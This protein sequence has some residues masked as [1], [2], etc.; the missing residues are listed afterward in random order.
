MKKSCN[1]GPHEARD[2]FR[3]GIVLIFASVRHL[4]EQAWNS[5]NF[6]IK[7][8]RLFVVFVFKLNRVQRQPLQFYFR[9]EVVQSLNY[10][11]YQISPR[12]LACV[13][14]ESL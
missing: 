1:V 5:I 9:L 13:I 3:A 14:V 11:S 2:I 8:W 7:R 10:L 6:E 4:S 12:L